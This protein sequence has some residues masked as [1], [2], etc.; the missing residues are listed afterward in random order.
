MQAPADD[1]GRADDGILI[2]V[3]PVTALGV[4]TPLEV[5]AELLLDRPTDAL[6]EIDLSDVVVALPGRRAGRQLQVTIDE[7]AAARG[8]RAVPPAI[9]T[10]PELDTAF[11][12]GGR[13]VAAETATAIAAIEAALASAV[14]GDA[15][16]STRNDALR[17][18]PIDPEPLELHALARRLL[19]ADRLVRAAD[20]TWSQVADAA[21]ARHGD[22]RRYDGIAAVLADARR[23]L[24]DVGL[25]WRDDV[26]DAAIGRLRAAADDGVPP[27][28]P[29][30]LVLLGTVDIARRDRRLVLAA[31]AAGVRVRPLLIA[32][33]EHVARFDDLGGVIPEA[34]STDPPVVP[35]DSIR[36]ESRPIDA[37]IAVAEWLFERR[38]DAGL[39]P[40]D[41]AI[42]LADETEGETI[43]RE[44]EAR[45]ATVHLGSGRPPLAT[46][47][48]RSLERLATWYEQ[49][50]TDAFGGVL[51]DPAM[52]AAIRREM[53]IGAADP[54]A[55]DSMPDSL[56]DPIP[57]AM[58]DPDPDPWQDWA[59]WSSE[60]MPRPAAPGWMQ[61]TGPPPSSDAV[62]RRL[63]RRARRLDAADAAWRRLADGGDDPAPLGAQID[64][65]LRVLARIDGAAGDASPWSE[66]SLRAV[67]EAADPLRAIPAAFEPTVGRGD[68]VTRLLQSLQSQPLPDPGDPSAI[69]TIGWL[70]SPFDPA[71]HLVL[72]G[73]HDAAVPGR[74]EDPLL[75][76]SVRRDLGLEHA[77]RRAARDAWVLSTALGRDP[78]CRVV[79]PR[80]DAGGEE[81]VPSRLLFGDRGEALAYR[82]KHLF[83]TVDDRPA[84]TTDRTAFARMTPGASPSA[85]P[86]RVERPTMSVTEFRTFLQ[87]PFRYWLRHV[88]E[89]ET[90]TPIGRELDARFFGIVLHDAVEAFGRN[91]L[92]RLAAGQSP[93]FDADAIHDEM[94][95]G[96]RDSLATRS[97]GSPGAGLRLQARILERR[98]RRIAEVQAARTLDGWRIHAV[99]WKIDQTLEMPDGPSQRITGRIDRIDRH[100]EHGWML[101]D[102]KTSDSNKSPDAAHRKGDGTWIDLQLPLY[103]WAAS[104]EA[105]APEIDRISSGYFIA[106]SSPGRIGIK[107]SKKIDPLFDEAIDTAREVVHA[108]RS[109]YFGDLGDQLSHGPHAD[110]PVALLMRTTALATD[111]GGDDE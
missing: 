62:R 94:L 64:A 83:R 81:L 73:L 12:G 33:P 15:G 44:L 13:P 21:E 41:V 54:D 23:R 78:A 108:I 36:V 1:E 43:R 92:A 82:V 45:G 19:D 56:P 99:E 66:A 111:D 27:D 48:A 7:V 80:R 98:L 10:L 89:L 28:G 4:A 24:A 38:T 17:W 14:R 25:A 75:P 9:T 95:A 5:A 106:G 2:G 26:I 70:E 31:G 87:S 102:F 85:S 35:L 72:V 29:C 93:L 67:R 76:Q 79:L 58:V 74:S 97:L 101:L 88:L 68:A 61:P 3:D 22:R 11:R 16:S 110:D 65:I 84:E 53:V 55:P 51:G 63:E 90:G 103:R 46:A 109:G 86:R 47:I 34:W 52:L 20:R 100:D 59:A 50:D 6:G 60:Q 18:L 42:V 107:A 39:D 91:E 71:P 37:A 8:V 104:F 57:D 96:L 105:D 77:E 40:D 49:L 69:E 30:E 32:P